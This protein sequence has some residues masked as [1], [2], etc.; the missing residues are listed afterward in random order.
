[1]AWEKDRLSNTDETLDQ[2]WAVMTPTVRETMEM[3][4]GSTIKPELD[5]ERTGERRALDV[6]TEIARIGESALRIESEIA[7]GGMGV[8]HL[9]TQTAL[10]RKVAVKVLKPNKRGPENARALLREAWVT[11]ALEHPNVIPV[12]DMGLDEQGDPLIVFKLIEGIEWG[13]LIYEPQRLRQQFGVE[14]PLRWHLQTLMQVCRAVHFA[15]SRGIV[16]R[17]LKPE[18]VMIGAYGEVYVLDW[19]IAVSTQKS[20]HL[21]AANEARALAGTPSYM[22]PEMLKGFG[23]DERT[24]VYLLGGILF[25]MLAEEP[26]HNGDTVMDML[27]SVARSEP[28][29]PTHGPPEL[30]AICRKALARDPSDRFT[31]AEDL[32]LALQAFLDHRGSIELSAQ[33][34]RRLAEMMSLLDEPEQ[35]AQIYKLFGECRFGFLQSLQIWPENARASDGLQSAVRTMIDW[36]LAAGDHRA[37][38]MLVTEMRETA[39]MLLQRIEEVK[40]GAEKSQARIAQL[41]ALE[42]Q[43]DRSI[44]ARTRSIFVAIMGIL[45]SV[46]PVARI[47]TG[48]PLDNYA[49][50]TMGPVIF[51]VIAGGLAW[52]GRHTLASTAINRALVSALFLAL[53]GVVLYDIGGMLH[54]VPPIDLFAQHLFFYALVVGTVSVTVEHRVWPTAVGFLLAYWV[55]MYSMDFVFFAT[56]AGNIVLAVNAWFVWAKEDPKANQPSV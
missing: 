32:R 8:V 5:A 53:M 33:A 25:E 55:S 15:H 6:L 7:E 49:A 41:E 10:E 50:I 46:G 56:S 30:V 45:F 31:T 39:P 43:R 44:G 42:T 14:D 24:D 13:E 9:A 12:Y 47:V 18:N 17:D 20:P 21:P 4:P 26:P 34:E 51:A 36:E 48:V 29:L 16:H 23:V 52:M 37:A 28:K 35:R 40:A 19:G 22:A 54:G 3:R 2:L 27:R 38:A 1:M 11:G